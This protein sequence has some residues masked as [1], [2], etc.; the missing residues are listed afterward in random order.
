MTNLCGHQVL[1]NAAHGEAVRTVVRVHWIDVRAV[2]VQV[3]STSAYCCT[4]PIVA[5]RSNVVQRTI[6]VV[7]VACCWKE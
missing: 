6:T 5:V 3:V 4:T 7:P 1:G 2:E